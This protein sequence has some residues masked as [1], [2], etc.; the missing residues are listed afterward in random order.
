MKRLLTTLFALTAIA[1][2]ASA[3]WAWAP[4]NTGQGSD[5]TYVPSAE[6]AGY[7]DNGPT[8]YCIIS[9]TTES[10]DGQ[11][12][13]KVKYRVEA[14]DGWGG[15]VVRVHSRDLATLGKA[16]NYD[17]QAGKYLSFWIKNTVAP[18]ITNPG[19]V[20]F[21]FKLKEKA[22]A[23][24][25]GE[26]RFVHSFGTVLQTSPNEW[27]QLI[28]PLEAA[29]W[30]VMQEGNEDG[31][32]TPWK[33]YGW[34][35]AVV[36]IPGTGGGDPATAATGEFIIDNMQILGQRFNPLMSFDNQ[37]DTTSNRTRKDATWALNDMSWDGAAGA[38]KMMLSNESVDT[39]QGTGAMKAEYAVVGTQDWG[40]YAELEHIFETPV[41]LSTN[42]GF[43]MYVKTLVANQLKGRL[44]LRLDV[45]DE[46]DGALEMWTT[47]IN[48]D[49]DNVTDWQY[50]QMPFDLTD[51]AWYNLKAGHTGFTKREGNNDGVFNTDKIKKVRIGFI[52]LRRAG[53]PFG[54]DVIANGTVLFDLWTP[55]GF[56]DIDTQAPDPVQDVLGLSIEEGKNSIVWADN[57]GEEKEKYNVYYSYEPITENTDLTKEG[58]FALAS[59][60]S[61]SIGSATHVFYNPLV[62]A[63][64][65][66]FYAVS[67]TDKSGNIG[68]PGGTFDAVASMSKAAPLVSDIA[69]AGFVADGDLSEWASI[70]GWN[71]K[72]SDGSAT[73]IN[74]ATWDIADD[75][76]A[77]MEAKAA[78]ADGFLYVAI[79]VTDDVYFV[80]STK[81][82]YN[83]D[84]PDLFFGLYKFRGKNH[85]GY[86]RGETPDYHFRF[87]F[88]KV[89]NDLN[90][91]VV[92]RPGENYKWVKTDTGYQLEWKI[93]IADL[94]GLYAGDVATY[95]VGDMIPIDWLLNDGDETNERV[96]AL[97]WSA[98]SNEDNG[99]NNVTSWGYT[100]V[101]NAGTKF[102]YTNVENNGTQPIEFAL[103]QNYPNPFNPST[104]VP[105]S[106]KVSGKVTLKVYNV[107]GAE[108]ATLFDGFKDAGIHSQ[109]FN[110]ASLSSGVYFVRM[111]ASGFSSVI[112]MM[113]LK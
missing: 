56:K 81:D 50:V 113:Y 54:S 55:T 3:Q 35:F 76:D 29:D 82:S 67:C 107:L 109:S 89:S 38:R 98:A 108:V 73:E 25:A 23:D 78:L 86:K 106:V 62:P 44:L 11:G 28:V 85:V 77:S 40:G 64:F 102:V 72:I 93:A 79:K 42:S 100:W 71:L 43:A 80:D 31:E 41:D 17:L 22:S 10:K 16:G 61:E 63:S 59:G 66:H 36:Y 4:L 18:T 75:N 32:F 7:Y 70:S 99:W 104:T 48:A 33:C 2:L 58:V 74:P 111:N 103:N 95:E 12:A 105:F 19:D 8:A 52:V 45:S 5:E 84:A 24:A 34:E 26:D 15:Y 97:R 47:V 92:A 65:K 83:Q 68:K 112:K 39:V 1:S 51:T 69:P 87:N 110:A 9:D 13:F 101:G 27:V 60:V 14:G 6:N 53:E 57:T 49:V 90:G 94:T 37:S 96:G 30:P 91:S 46:K 88:H 20:N 21:E